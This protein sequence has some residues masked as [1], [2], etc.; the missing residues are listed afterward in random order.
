LRKEKVN[1][2]SL[3]RFIP[4]LFVLA[5]LGMIAVAWV[6]P[7]PGRSDSAIPLQTIIDVG[8]TLI[9]FFYGL[10]LSPEKMKEGMANW[11]IHTT[12]QSITF[13]LFPLVVLPFYFIAKD[14]AYEPLWLGMFFLAALPSTVSSSVV[15]VSLAKGNVA[16]AIFNASIS[17]IIGIV[18]TP[19]WIG[20][21]WGQ[22]SG[23]GNYSGI[24]L[25]LFTQII[26]PAIAGLLLH[27]F[28]NRWVSKHG[29]MLSL[30][31][32]ATILLIVYKSFAV[33][34]SSGA[35]ESIDA[36][37]LVLLFVV[38]VALFG[39]IITITQKINAKIGF[40][41]E[42]SIT[43]LFCG[44]KKSLAHGTV[45]ASVLFADVQGSGLYLLPIMVYHAFQLFYISLM[46]QKMR[47][48][49]EPAQTINI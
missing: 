32:K 46:A 35:F 21:F 19:L 9:F 13:L 31:D 6:F 23:M 1:Q 43:V 17:G 29:R 30:F 16:G 20:L 47:K 27:R 12:I 22:D 42:D 37:S 7:Q 34:F 40:N 41:R 45:M 11:R 14:T 39:T 8:V 25:D 10:K 4:D 3:K 5:L 36:L 18:A 44:S 38:V 49:V 15:M 28:F 24:L 48:E 2:A 33:S 26:V